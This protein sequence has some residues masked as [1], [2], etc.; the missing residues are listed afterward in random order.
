[1]LFLKKPCI[2]GLNGPKSEIVKHLTGDE[3]ELKI[4]SIL[5]PGGLGKTTLAREVFQELQNQFDCAAFIYVGRYPSVVDTLM[6]ITGQV[7]RKSLV[8][9]DERLIATELW[10]FL[11]TKRYS[12]CSPI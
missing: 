5:G 3:Q 6:D 1:M 2:V 10:K 11:F 4:V 8:P 7:M 9:C 12:L